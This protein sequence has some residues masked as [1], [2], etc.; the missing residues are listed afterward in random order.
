MGRRLAREI[1]LK[2]LYRYEEGNTDVVGILHAVLDHKNY[3]NGEKKFSRELVEKTINNLSTIDTAIIGV[4]KNWPYDRIAVIDKTI[5]RIG[6]C[7]ILYCSDIP[8]QVSINEAIEISKKYSS[9][10]SGKF[11]NGILDA[12]KKTY[13][14]SNHK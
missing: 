4:L 10:D 3:S 9:G 14:S 12:I 13:E 7:E 2:I 8:A 6:V 11:V 5:L 1:A